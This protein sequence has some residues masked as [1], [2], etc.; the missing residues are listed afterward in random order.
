VK[1]VSQQIHLFYSI[2]RKIMFGN[3]LEHFVNLPRVNRCKTCVSGPNAP[4][5][6]T[7]FAKMVSHQIQPF[8]SIRPKMILMSILEHFVNLPRA[9]RCKTCVSV[10]NALFRGTQ[11]AKMVSH[12]LH[13]L[14]SFAPKMMIGSVLE[15]FGIFQNVKDAKLVFW[16]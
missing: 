3:V 8:Y 4:F 15:H 1:I 12:L 14:Y 11:V 7:P 13:P 6:G 5:R 2:R 10:P 16:A 9:K